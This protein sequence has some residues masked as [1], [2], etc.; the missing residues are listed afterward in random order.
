MYLFTFRSAVSWYFMNTEKYCS[1]LKIEENSNLKLRVLI[2]NVIFKLCVSRH[3]IK[4]GITF[5]GKY[6]FDTRE[7]IAF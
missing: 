4:R 1:I 7:N 5:F 6:Y 3:Y 2:L